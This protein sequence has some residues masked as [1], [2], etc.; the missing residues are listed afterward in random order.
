MLLLLKVKTTTNYQ[1]A[2]KK[3]KLLETPRELC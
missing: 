1:N 2:R 3:T